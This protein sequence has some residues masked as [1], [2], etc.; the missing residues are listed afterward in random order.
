VPTL[1]ALTEVLTG[2][3]KPV[4]SLPV[5]ASARYPIGAG[6]RDFT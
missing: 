2:A 3:R 1:R 4:G 6:M 5:T